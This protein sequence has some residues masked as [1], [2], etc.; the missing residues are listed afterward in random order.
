MAELELGTHLLPRGQVHVDRTGA[1]VV[2]TRHRQSDP[3]AP[4][5][6]RAEHVDRGPDP[7]DLLVR[8][9]RRE[10]PGVRQGEPSRLRSRRVDSDGGEQ[11]AHARD[12]DDR[13]NVGQFVGAVGED[14]RGHQLEDRV[15]RPRHVDRAPELT[16][17]T[18]DDLVGRRGHKS[19][20]IEATPSAGTNSYAPGVGDA[21]RRAARRSEA[22]RAGEAKRSPVEAVKVAIVLS[23]S[24]STVGPSAITCAARATTSS[25]SGQRGTE[26][27]SR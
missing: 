20:R 7:L 2:A 12:V 4:G 15:L 9:D 25:S 1:E 11:V 13:R 14:R 10:V 22:P 16:D 21:E 27:S 26:R 6:Q 17:A 24:G 3:A 19:R 23:G 18:D 8:R 5:E